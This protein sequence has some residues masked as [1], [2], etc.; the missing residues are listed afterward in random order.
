M[1]NF[2]LAIIAVLLAIIA[3]LLLKL[4]QRPPATDDDRAI[5]G[6]HL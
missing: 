1:T 4:V 2:L 5:R 6:P 3:M